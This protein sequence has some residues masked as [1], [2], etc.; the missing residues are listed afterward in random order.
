MKIEVRK[1][2]K[3]VGDRCILEVED[4]TLESGKIYAVLGLNGAG[5]TT[6]L[7]VLSGIE[8]EADTDILYDGISERPGD[9]I[10]HLTQSAYLFD[11]T[12]RKN[13][14]LGIEDRG[15]TKEEMDGMVLDA[16]KRVRME[17]FIDKKARSL[18]G[19]EAQRVALARALIMK[20]DM[21]ILD[22]PSSA[23]DVRGAERMEDYIREMNEKEGTTFL[24]TTH[25][26][27]Q[28]MRLADE[29]IF[30]D[31]G[32]VIEKGTPA[33]ILH[34]PVDRET[35]RFFRNWRITDV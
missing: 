23:T 30:M 33:K 27:S 32:R 8:K 17:E 3:T 11:T 31:C 20:K 24:L 14:V 35:E 4:L 18:S 34:E 9:R 26:P 25:N 28:A 21:V 29:I 15:H 22:E 1:A 16:L 12:V 5:K 10:V 7:R 2:H 13:M 6:L 19:G